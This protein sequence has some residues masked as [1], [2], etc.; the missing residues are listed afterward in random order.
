MS[1]KMA[2]GEIK[3]IMVDR[4]Y[5]ANIQSYDDSGGNERPV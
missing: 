4:D 2:C 1:Y 3:R 5:P